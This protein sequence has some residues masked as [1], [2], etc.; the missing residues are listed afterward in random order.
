MNDVTTILL[1]HVKGI[2]R[3]SYREKDGDEFQ[4]MKLEGLEQKAASKASLKSMLES[5][6]RN[7]Q[8]S[9]CTEPMRLLYCSDHDASML[10]LP[11][12]ENGQNW[13]LQLLK[14]ALQELR[15]LSSGR[16]VLNGETVNSFSRPDVFKWE[17]DES[18]LYLHTLP[19]YALQGN[20]RASG[21][22]E[23][24][25]ED[26]EQADAPRQVKK[27]FDVFS[28]LAEILGEENAQKGTKPHARDAKFEVMELLREIM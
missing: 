13:S 5:I 4:I 21:L 3:V 27:E 11:V 28:V 22:D 16:W 2:Y 6:Q 9:Y 23:S 19:T 12:L 18:P 8:I 1:T 10:A 26:A 25:H 14:D 17:G 24:R 7:L 20:L 15:F